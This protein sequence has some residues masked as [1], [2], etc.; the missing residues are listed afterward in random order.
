M[1]ETFH[2]LPL[3]VLIGPPNTN[4][5]F[6]GSVALSLIGLHERGMFNGLTLAKSVDLL[7]RMPFFVFNDP[8]SPEVLKLLITKVM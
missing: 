8:D 2:Q 3:P 4:K 1:K 6:L 5:T 7:G